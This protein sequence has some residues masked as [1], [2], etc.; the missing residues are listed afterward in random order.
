M[1]E[2]KLTI[3]ENSAE[4]YLKLPKEYRMFVQGYMQGVIL[5]ESERQTAVEEKERAGDDSGYGK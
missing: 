1:S 4:K 5:R 2:E 3:I